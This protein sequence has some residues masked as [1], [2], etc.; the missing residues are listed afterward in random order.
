MV[1]AYPAQKLVIA[2][3]ANQT[4]I[5]ASQIAKNIETTFLEEAA[6]PQI[7]S[8]SAAESEQYLG[9]FQQITG[10]QIGLVRHIIKKENDFFYHRPGS[11]DTQIYPIGNDEF[12]MPFGNQRA[13]IIIKFDPITNKRQLIFKGNDGKPDRLYVEIKTQATLSSPTVALDNYVGTY[14]SEE[15]QLTWRIDLLNEELII[16]VNTFTSPLVTLK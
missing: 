12:I 9:E 16:D 13:D 11:V 1:K 6:T 4:Q 14:T 15:T 5:D 3:L 2:V 7:I 10:S 8:L